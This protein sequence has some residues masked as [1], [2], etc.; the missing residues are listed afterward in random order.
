MTLH[1]GSTG[2][3]LHFGDFLHCGISTLTT[4]GTGERGNSWGDVILFLGQRIPHQLACSLGSFKCMLK[5]LFP[6]PYLPA[7]IIQIEFHSYGM[8]WDRWFNMVQP[9]PIWFFLLSCPGVHL[10]HAYHDILRP[11]QGDW[12]LQCRGRTWWVSPAKIIRISTARYSLHS[13]L[14]ERY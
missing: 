13:P 11:S 8:S 7:R 5:T 14:C 12:H 10:L 4:F 6:H 2:R 3:A 9:L 1:L